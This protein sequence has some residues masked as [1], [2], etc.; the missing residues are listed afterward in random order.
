MI[1]STE[2]SQ[3][4]KESGSKRDVE[5]TRN[6]KRK[7][8]SVTR[9]SAS[10]EL[11]H[12][13]PIKKPRRGFDGKF[14]RPVCRPPVD[15]FVWDGC[16]GYWIPRGARKEKELLPRRI[17]SSSD[18][19]SI[20]SEAEISDSCCILNKASR[21]Y[22][23]VRES[24][25]LRSKLKIH[26]NQRP[27]SV[28]LRKSS[29]G[30]DF[31]NSKNQICSSKDRTRLYESCSSADN[32]LPENT[33]THHRHNDAIPLKSRKASVPPSAFFTNVGKS[34]TRQDDVTDPKESLVHSS[35]SSEKTAS[36]KR[37]KRD[38]LVHRDTINV[39]SRNHC[40]ND[41]SYH[42]ESMWQEP[43][44]SDDS[45]LTLYERHRKPRAIPSGMYHCS[46][47]ALKQEFRC[48]ICLDYIRNARVVKECLHR[49]CE[50]CIEKALIQV[51]RRNECPI[52]RVF[53]PTRRSLAPD[54][55]FDRLIKCI[56]KDIA[57]VNE[58]KGKGEGDLFGLHANETREKNLQQFIRE[59]R[60]AYIQKKMHSPDKT[61]GDMNIVKGI[62]SQNS[63]NLVEG[64][65]CNVADLAVGQ[66]ALPAVVNIVFRPYLNDTNVD[67]LHLPF[68]TINGSATVKVLRKFLEAKLCC[69]NLQLFTPLKDGKCVVHNDRKTVKEIAIVAVKRKQHCEANY[70]PI[71][72]RSVQR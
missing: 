47:K 52:C 72:Y 20:E 21:E 5:G 19:T 39:S 11:C 25:S 9:A 8:R 33:Y 41:E 14:I 60:V 44:P 6:I 16:S 42:P 50:T 23:F 7:L 4:N 28:S 30:V 29:A 45:I 53:V 71:F 24:D 57:V 36:R 64:S 58:T 51:G 27:A 46:L 32:H 55:H 59:N 37:T 40:S 70:I 38:L 54:P 63:L 62:E 67:E 68:F 43:K 3:T 22:S 35:N 12:I 31:R 65:A 26:D 17:E 66:S 69:S 10:R 18:C 15:G 61:E 34:Q 13:L 48:A 1:R 56:L 2:G 49:F